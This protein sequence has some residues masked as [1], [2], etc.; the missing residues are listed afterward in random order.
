M[1]PQAES[2][3]RQGT[4]VDRMVIAWVRRRGIVTHLCPCSVGI[5]RALGNYLTPSQVGTSPCP[6]MLAPLSVSWPLAPFQPPPP[7][8]PLFSSF[9]WPAPPWSPSPVSS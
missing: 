5:P 1:G 8:P 7:T 2:T 4:P 3:W 6:P 9:H